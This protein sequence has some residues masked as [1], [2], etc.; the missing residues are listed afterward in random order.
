MAELPHR[1]GVCA[2]LGRP[3]AGKST[4]LN[5][6]LGEKLAIVT[7]KPQ[8]T[9]SRIL[10]VLTLANAQ[11]LLFDTPGVHGLD[12]RL[13]A[14]MRDTIDEVA[15]DCD[16]ACL[17]VDPREGLGSALAE[18]LERLRRR[19]APVLL[20]A[21]KAD[22][23]AVRELP[24]PPPGAPPADASLRVSAHSGEGLDALLAAIVERLPE[25]PPLYPEDELSDRP[26]R[27]LAAELV[28]EAA[29]EELADE[30]PYS[31][32]VEIVEWKEPREGLTRIRANLIL[33]RAS[34][35]RI[36]VGQGGAMVK[37]IGVRARREIEPLVGTQVHLE[38][39]VKL[40]PRWARS[41]KRLK[42]LGYS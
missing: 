19:G 9:R 29:F 25:S 23:P 5:V 21:T 3:N 41:P 28:R 38:L 22:L 14:A 20:V 11:V 6:L 37:R 10:G 17:L 27:F 40:E 33:E 42:S 35:K 12:R 26:V 31:L 8:T 36:V 18:L 32:A 39:W 13:N 30:I 2:L 34:Q 1:T 16:V 7:A 24:W 15:E 4:L